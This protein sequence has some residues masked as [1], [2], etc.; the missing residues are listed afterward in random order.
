MKENLMEVKLYENDEIIFET[1]IMQ[2]PKEMYLLYHKGIKKLYTHCIEF[3][4]FV[5]AID[6]MKFYKVKFFSSFYILEK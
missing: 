3:D 2:L 4:N 1:K 6:V 5:I